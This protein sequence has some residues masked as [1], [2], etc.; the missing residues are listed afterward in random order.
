MLI[1]FIKK[2]WFINLLILSS[3]VMLTFLT[4]HLWGLYYYGRPIKALIIAKGPRYDQISITYNFEGEK[5]NVY[6][7]GGGSVTDQVGDEINIIV[8][9]E[10]PRKI[11]RTKDEL[12]KF[13]PTPTMLVSFSLMLL[14]VISFAWF[15]N[16]RVYDGMKLQK[17]KKTIRSKN[18]TKRHTTP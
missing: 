6:N 7:S 5:Y 13:I 2:T 3:I 1:E 18:N 9:A 10:N 14:L 11:M 8:N 16:Y 15:I 17:K 12:V 4:H